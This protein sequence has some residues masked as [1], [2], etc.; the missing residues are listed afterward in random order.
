MAAQAPQ[1]ASEERKDTNRERFL[2]AVRAI[3]AG[4][5]ANM[6]WKLFLEGVI[7]NELYLDAVN[8]GIDD[9]MENEDYEAYML[10]RFDLCREK[11]QLR[12]EERSVRQQALD[13]L[14]QHPNQ[15]MCFSFR[16]KLDGAHVSG[17]YNVLYLPRL[18]IAASYKAVWHAPHT[19]FVNS[20]SAFKVVNLTE[21]ELAAVL[22]AHGLTI[23]ID[24]LTKERQV[25][26]DK[27]R[28]L[29]A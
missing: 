8:E 26:C 25:E 18:Q 23:R 14:A 10:R 13:G 12:N 24:Q 5:T 16:E 9:T 7:D 1:Q 15:A 17:T 27:L 3:R 22:A 2:E 20:N 4:K 28:T 29:L 19:F 11:M 21:A 6:L